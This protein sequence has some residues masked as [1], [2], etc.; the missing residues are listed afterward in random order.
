M[1]SLMYVIKMIDEKKPDIFETFILIKRWVVDNDGDF[2]KI[3][4][5]KKMQRN[6]H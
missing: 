2:H 3:F 4:T 6:N 1:N 5:H